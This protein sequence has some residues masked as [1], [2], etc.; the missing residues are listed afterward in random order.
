MTVLEHKRRMMLSQR[1]R[2]MGR[3]PGKKC[4]LLLIFP[5]WHYS[6]YAP[7]KKCTG[8]KNSGMYNGE[9]RHMGIFSGTREMI[10]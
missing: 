6:S 3:R 4:W 9:T 2:V 5:A 1:D 10:G 7:S 8:S